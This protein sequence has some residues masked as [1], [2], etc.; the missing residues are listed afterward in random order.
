MRFG[1]PHPARDPAQGA[2]PPG[3]A[4]R[5]ASGGGRA[6]A[7]ASPARWEM[8]LKERSSIGPSA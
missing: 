8:S 2:G 7:G 4:R 3:G 5:R 1:P 6:Q